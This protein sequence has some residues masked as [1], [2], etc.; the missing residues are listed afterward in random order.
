[1]EDKKTSSITTKG[2]TIKAV[3]QAGRYQSFQMTMNI[4]QVLISIS[5]VM[6]MP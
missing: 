5:P 6:E 4:M 3:S 1:L 2:A